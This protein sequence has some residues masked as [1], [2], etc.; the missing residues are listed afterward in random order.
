MANHQN[1]ERFDRVQKVATAALALGAGAAF[2]YRGGGNKALSSG[3][4]KVSTALND[5]RNI[6]SKRSLAEMHGNGKAYLSTARETFRASFKEADNLKQTLRVD[7]PNSLI[8]S[9]QIAHSLESEAGKQK[10][11]RKMYQG[12]FDADLKYALQARREAGDITSAS[13]RKLNNIVDNASTHISEAFQYADYIDDISVKSNDN[14]RLSQDFKDKNF[15]GINEH[16]RNLIEEIL[17]ER[18]QAKKAESQAFME[19]NKEII[20][21]MAR[22]ISS[23][24]SLAERFGT[25]QAPKGKLWDEVLG[26]R[27]ATINEL[28]EH[29]DKVEQTDFL[30]TANEDPQSILRKMRDMVN[31][32]ERFGDLL[33]DPTLRFKNGEIYSLAEFDNTVNKLEND[34]M[35]TLFGKI[36]KP[37]ETHY[38]KKNAPNF[39]FS[40]AGS[41]DYLLPALVEGRQSTT[42]QHSYVRLNNRGFRLT[43]NG[44]E[45]V[46]EMD[47]VFPTSGRFG[48]HV[49]LYKN[50][51]GDVDYLNKPRG[52][53]K[54]KLDLGTS[55]KLGPLQEFKLK[56]ARKHNPDWL[57]NIVESNLTGS[58]QGLSNEEYFVQMREIN[59][60]YKQS[61]KK[62]DSTTVTRLA[63]QVEDNRTREIFDLLQM[64]DDQLLK[65]IAQPGFETRAQAYENADA[66]S[67]L[68]KYKADPKGAVSSVSISTQ[69]EALPIA[70]RHTEAETYTD[71]LRKELDK[72]ALMRY[73]KATNREAVLDMIDNANLSHSEKEQTKNLL[74]WANFQQA[75]H[76]TQSS[77][78][79]LTEGAMEAGRRD[80]QQ[81]FRGIN[82]HGNYE[83]DFQRSIRKMVK[84]NTTLLD[85]A[86]APQ[87]HLDMIEKANRPNE[88]IYVRKSI[89]GLDVI[90]NLNDTEKA[91][92]YAKQ[93]F[94]GRNNMQDFTA[95]SFYPYFGLF[96]LMD[97][98]PGIGFSP[99]NTKNVLDLAKNI[100]MRRAL[101]IVAAGTVFSY[102]NYEARNFTGRSLTEAAA[103]SFSNFDLGVRKIQ[104]TFGISN[105]L[106]DSFYT[107]PGLR[108]WSDDEHRTAEEQVE[109]YQNGKSP[110]RKGRW[111]GMLSSSEFR[112][113]KIEY[114]EHNY[115]KQASVPWQD[116]GV[117]G[118]EEEKWKHS[119][120]P[121]LRHPLSTLR[122]L[123]NPYWLEEKNKYSRPYPMTAPMFGEGTP[124]SGLLNATIG[125]AIK[126]VRRMHTEVLGNDYVDVR[127]LIA[128]RN[129]A[130]K[131]KAGSSQL[132]LTGSN[133]GTESPL[134]Y[135]G[136]S[137]TSNQRAS[138]AVLTEFNALALGSGENIAAGATPGSEIFIPNLRRSEKLN[139]VDKLFLGSMHLGM[140]MPQLADINAQIKQKA[141]TRGASQTNYAKSYDNLIAA[142]TV[143]IM[144]SSDVQSDL[145]HI[146]SRKEFLQDASY[147]AKQLSG[148]YGFLLDEMI[149]GTKRYALEN[150]GKMGSFTT[151][152]WDESI[153]GVGGEFMEIARRF[154]PHE[155]HDIT[156]LNPIRNNMPSWMP[157]RFKHGDPYTQVKKGEMR[158]PG[159]AYEAMNNYTPNFDFSIHPYMIGANKDELVQYFL[160]KSNA[161]NYL[162]SM[163]IQEVNVTNSMVRSTEENIIKAQKT[164]K[165]LL[166]SGRISRGEFYSDFEKFKILADVAPWSQEY[167]EMKTAVKATLTAE[168][169]KEYFEILKRVQKQST[170]HEFYN[171]NYLHTKMVEE[172]AII[173]T[174][175]DTGFTVIG[176]DKTYT[177]AGVETTKEALSTK[178]GAG[179]EV[180]LKYE[181]N[182]QGENN[183]NTIVYTGRDNVSR[184][185]VKENLATRKSGTAV[186]A[187]ALASET[188]KFIGTVTEF[189]GHMPIPF[190]HNKFLK[191][192]TAR[193]SYE[194]EQ[195]YGTPYA[196]WSHPIEGYIEPA[197]NQAMNVSATHA[198][199]GATAF[200]A[201]TYM[202]NTTKEFSFELFGKTIDNLSLQKAANVA[203]ILATP[204]ASAGAVTGYL[205]KLNT[206]HVNT[207]ATIGA[208]IWGVGYLYTNA[209]NPFLAAG[210]GASIGKAFGDWYGS[211]Y[212]AAVGAAVGL[213]I[214]H[215]RNPDFHIREMFKKW[216]PE[217]TEKR[218]ELEEYFDRLEYIKYNALYEKAAEK[219]LKEEGVNIRQILKG[220]EEQE[221]KHRN[222]VNRLLDYKQKL[223]NSFVK[224]S[225][226]GKELMNKI[227]SELV[228]PIESVTVE[229][230]EWTKSALAYKQARD[231]TIYA[232]QED[233]SWAQILR[234]L[235]K[236]DRDYFLEFAKVKDKKEQDKI[237]KTISPYKRKILQSIWGRRIDK[238]ESNTSYFQGHALPNMFWKGWRPDV[239]MDHIQ[240]KTI[241]NEGL[242]LSDFGFYDSNKQEP[243]Y[244][245]VEPIKN[246]DTG[247]DLLSVKAN[248]LT[249]LHGMG[250]AGVN[251]SIQPSQRP[252]IQMVADFAR[253]TDYNIKNKVNSLFGR[254]YY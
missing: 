228:D 236:N 227:N 159:L 82:E 87:S 104:D 199:I 237:L 26:D 41:T 27:Q 171:Y 224:N 242:L 14:F 48:S 231:S 23:Y 189:I 117:Y 28:L 151:R 15:G 211:K 216:I 83:K 145:A 17:T 7:N 61:T 209:N 3:F 51:T 251:V 112:G 168:Q 54:S 194:N 67:L 10:F 137:G 210:A 217:D 58:N 248:L 198:V 21:A 72:E 46:K 150:A 154:F 166:E 32:D 197:F 254:T 95:S 135:G 243:G 174:I 239:D 223:Q 70:G 241:E 12:K 206:D 202:A 4:R 233:A 121:T 207:G 252:G 37:L 163:P 52:Y 240:M 149:P 115:L 90:R 144:R 205:T 33:V 18:F 98:I 116:I 156:Y 40:A 123:A 212:G 66:V 222:N 71:L 75:S 122:Y 253:V 19:N 213:G 69:V 45:R 219:A 247:A 193:E 179:M 77:M 74:H 244:E 148:I 201:K 185:L 232:L 172:T 192:E 214:S 169:Q 31:K 143:D 89:S 108:Y 164:V 175:T 81:L 129:N 158:L 136:I 63:G 188:Q 103:V 102:L 2:L 180:R 173:D 131:A 246:F 84:E 190:L 107:N 134:T 181:A 99:E 110:V 80:T 105:F 56:L 44:L 187:Q 142:D 111:W 20:D 8:N 130:I 139:F 133:S 36:A 138:Q 97:A 204:G 42:L 152:F 177:L 16:D 250:L 25:L 157:E 155:N 65:T 184:L 186:D 9:L 235:P 39:I 125:E 101:P 5:T 120:I 94:A 47:D 160:N 200:A 128:A 78:S 29:A 140:A 182:D 57:P 238:Q 91:K 53:I 24:D 153:G 183:I 68:K 100:T 85:D 191:L 6:M 38:N 1:D 220:M 141:M 178:L 86:G 92:A 226:Y 79:P 93:F 132:T 249:T 161:D 124:W 13:I 113:G 170:T 30:S 114:F 203:S 55:P 165:K 127:D 225:E 218:W 88:Y 11:A 59:R 230:G 162:N 34:F 234:A 50:V 176:S 146:S 62:L 73:Q 106:K 22:E 221:E 147:S 196:T 118:S 245:E 109:W 76:V 35:H 208:T 126:P 167:K 60:F 215:M 49:R 119:L 43:S 195:V 64:D 229:A 96:R